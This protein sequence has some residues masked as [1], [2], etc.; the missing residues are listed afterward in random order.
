MSDVAK[1]LEVLAA[2]EE[3]RVQQEALQSL[4]VTIPFITVYSSKFMSIS[5]DQQRQYLMHINAE[6]IQLLRIAEQNRR[7]NPS[8]LYKAVLILKGERKTH[9][10]I[11]DALQI[12]PAYVNKIITVTRKAAI[13]AG[14]Q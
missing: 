2:Q 3:S 4:N 10:Q 12:S 7:S 13:A 8:E 11:A 9:A 5:G 6:H 14:L 1:I